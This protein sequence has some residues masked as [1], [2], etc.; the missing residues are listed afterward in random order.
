[1]REY[2]RYVGLDVH[3]DT[4][5]VAVGIDAFAPSCCQPS[6]VICLRQCLVPVPEIMLKRNPSLILSKLC[7]QRSRPRLANPHR[8]YYVVPEVLSIGDGSEI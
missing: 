2:S 1:M 7:K 6:S 5:A 4:I 3:M 8:A